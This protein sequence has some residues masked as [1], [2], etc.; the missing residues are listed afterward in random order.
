MVLQQNYVQGIKFLFAKFCYTLSVISFD[1]YRRH[2]RIPNTE[3]PVCQTWGSDHDSCAEAT[4]D[5]ITFNLTK[6]INT[7][8]LTKQLFGHNY[9]QISAQ[10]TLE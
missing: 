10:S 4:I 8:T 2:T 3:L 7:F 5:Y 9:N 1:H 6:P